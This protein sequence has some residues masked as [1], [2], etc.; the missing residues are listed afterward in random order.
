MNL[1][2]KVAIVTGGARGIGGGIA[3]CLAE[4]GSTVAVLDLDGEG[5]STHA[6]KLGNSSIG[7]ECDA[8]SPE[9]AEEGVARVIAKYGRLDI[10]VNNAGAGRGPML[11][12]DGAIVNWAGGI[13]S[14]AAESWD[15]SMAQNLRTTF[16]MAK[17]AVPHLKIR[18]GAIVNISSIAGL[19]A[20]PTLAAYAAAKAG[21]ISLTKS[22]ALELAPN[23]IRVNAICPGFLWTR[24]WEGMA[25]A[26][27]KSNPAYAGQTPRQ[28]FEEIVKRGVPMQREQTPEDIGRLATFLASEWSHNI[29]GQF[30]SVDGGI[31]LR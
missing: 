13:T 7:F 2:G 3:T 21:V 26:I 17:A 15:E 11:I 8:A 1:Q 16:L 9:Q 4:A 12:P 5:A 22:L 29:T 19:G 25:T 30:I 31:T 6:S 23:D 10:L 27:Q 24:A 20:S 18:G 28:V 14:V